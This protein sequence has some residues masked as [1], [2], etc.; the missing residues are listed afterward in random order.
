MILHY[1]YYYYL[2]K[3]KPW[4]PDKNTKFEVPFIDSMIVYW[5]KHRIKILCVFGICDDTVP[6]KYINI[7]YKLA[8]S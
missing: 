7:Q 3:F 5:D 1:Y 4:Q 8:C 6:V 2:S